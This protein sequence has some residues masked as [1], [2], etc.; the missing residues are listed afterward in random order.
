MSL[1]QSLISRG[2]GA[3]PEAL[4]LP[5]SELE[6]GAGGLKLG[7]FVSSHDGGPVSCDDS[8]DVGGSM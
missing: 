2:E 6:V 4:Y 5:V 8:G 3:P 1:L 7:R